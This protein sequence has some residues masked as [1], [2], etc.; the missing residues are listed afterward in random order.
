MET[1]LYLLAMRSI[2]TSKIKPR[3]QNVTSVRERKIIASATVPQNYHTQAKVS[4]YEKKIQTGK[5]ML[6]SVRRQMLK[7]EKVLAEFKDQRKEN[8]KDLPVVTMEV[9]GV[10]LTIDPSLPS[11]ATDPFIVEKTD[12]AKLKFSNKA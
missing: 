6:D 12:R 7:L 5:A 1:Y 8:I 10:N 3:A 9:Y 11:L 4:L 2:Y